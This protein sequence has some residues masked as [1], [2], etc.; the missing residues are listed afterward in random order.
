MPHDHCTCSCCGEDGR[1]CEC[2]YNPKSE[3]SYGRK[4]C[5]KHPEKR[6]K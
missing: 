5:K 1:F 4:P 6:N 3:W 2:V